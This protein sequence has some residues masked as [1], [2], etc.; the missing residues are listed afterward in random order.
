MHLPVVLDAQTTAPVAFFATGLVSIA[1][2]GNT[3]GT[4]E[5]ALEA[6]YEGLERS[7]HALHNTGR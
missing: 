6:R 7:L 5:Y 4:R 3:Q 1:C 2:V